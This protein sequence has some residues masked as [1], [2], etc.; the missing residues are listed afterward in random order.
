M[1]LDEIKMD[2]SEGTSGPWIYRPAPYGFDVIAM[3]QKDDG[4]WWVGPVQK[5]ISPHSATHKGCIEESENIC[6]INARRIARLPELE[7]AYLALVSE[8]AKMRVA[9][10]EAADE[11]DSYYAAEYGGGHPYSVRKFDEA[12]ATNPARIALQENTD[13]RW[14]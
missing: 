2:R 5:I 3:P 14:K 13:D 4:G 8:I 7:D 6:E 12:R 11:L 10:S 1:L 9:L